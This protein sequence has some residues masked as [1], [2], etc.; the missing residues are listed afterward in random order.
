MAKLNPEATHRP[1]KK[2]SEQP[3]KTGKPPANEPFKPSKK[4]RTNLA[5]PR[6]GAAKPARPGPKKKGG[7]PAGDDDPARITTEGAAALARVRPEIEAVPSDQVR[8]INVYVPA[9]VL[10]VLGALPRLMTLR[11]QMRALSGHPPDALDKLRDYALAAAHAYVRALPQ[12]A[13]ETHLRAL[14]GE[15]APLRERLLRSA[16]L[17]AEFGLV[18]ATRVA[19]IR[20]GVGH[21][22]TALDLEGLGTL[23]REAWPAVASK[24][25]IT[26]AEV[27]RASQLGTLLLDALGQ[28]QSG[29]DGSGDPREA[30]E[31]L[32]KAYEL[33][34]RTYDECRRAVTYLRWHQGDADEFAPSLH[35]KRRRGRSAPGNEPDG[36]PD[37]EPD[38]EP[39]NEPGGEPEGEAAE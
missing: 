15:A 4:P 21:L 5:S 35:L 36:G 19:A 2:G 31:L 8:R 24:S 7:A 9:A 14:L 18:D 13:G 33:F 3:T 6:E 20:R 23:F 38:G 22:D 30:D 1:T 17:L 29:A 26:L 34:F 11:D 28:R 27:E 25:P 10:V 39:V 16:E 37:G 32:G 12:D